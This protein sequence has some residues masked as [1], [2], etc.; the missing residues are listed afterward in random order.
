M[1]DAKA[2]SRWRIPL[3]LVL[4][5]SPQLYFLYSPEL[6]LRGE[7]APNDITL[8]APKADGCV[9]PHSAPDGGDCQ[10]LGGRILRPDWACFSEMQR[11]LLEFIELYKERPI[12]SNGGGVGTL[13]PS[14]A[15]GVRSTD[16]SVASQ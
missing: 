15:D 10:A 4:F 16:G 3:L 8:S 1:V 2:L 7:I 12:K 13:T 9:E 14:Y 5:S 6:S 11:L